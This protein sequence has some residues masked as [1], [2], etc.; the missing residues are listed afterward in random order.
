MFI[1]SNLNNINHC[2]IPNKTFQDKYAFYVFW[3]Q[4]PNSD[5]M[6]SLDFI[7]AWMVVWFTR[8]R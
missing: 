5:Q 3:A 7:T 2:S 1:I 8:P 6:T 4:K